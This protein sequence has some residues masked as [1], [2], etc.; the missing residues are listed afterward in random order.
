MAWAFVLN[1]SFRNLGT[2]LAF[3]AA[4]NGATEKTAEKE[5]ASSY[6]DSSGTSVPFRTT[7]TTT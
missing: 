4:G 1:V 7:E 5:E 6:R 2:D 3:R